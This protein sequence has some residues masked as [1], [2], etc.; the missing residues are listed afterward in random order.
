VSVSFDHA[1]AAQRHLALI[2]SDWPQVNGIGITRK[3][4]GF[5]LKLN[6]TEGSPRAE[7]P[8]EVDGVPVQVEV[9]GRAFAH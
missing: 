4:D 6:L 8:A 9:V 1:R 5:G 3:G 7:V 2:L